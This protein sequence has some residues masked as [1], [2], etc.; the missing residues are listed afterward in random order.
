MD[1]VPFGSFLSFTAF[2]RFQPFG[3]ILEIVA[4]P[5]QKISNTELLV[6]TQTPPVPFRPSLSFAAFSAVIFLTTS[7]KSSC[8]DNTSRFMR[9][10][11]FSRKEMASLSVGKTYKQLLQQR[12]FLVGKPFEK[13]L[14]MS[15][16][17]SINGMY[18]LPKHSRANC[19]TKK[20][21]TKK[22]VTTEIASPMYT[23]V[24]L[25]HYSNRGRTYLTRI[26]KEKDSSINTFLSALTNN[27]FASNL[28]LRWPKQLMLVKA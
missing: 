9:F 14:W 24:C 25:M 18:D 20:R 26:K 13:K 10:A 23:L 5:P 11:R 27:Y 12:G 6:S 3:A 28:R 16:C 15:T 4:Q 7:S 8:N 2:L 22:M 21:F 1:A 17:S 19:W